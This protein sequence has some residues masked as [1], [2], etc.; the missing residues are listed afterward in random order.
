MRTTFQLLKGHEGGKER[1][2]LVVHVEI[3]EKSFEKRVVE[4]EVKHKV[5]VQGGRA[6]RCRSSNRL[7]GLK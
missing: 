5:N 6:P 2:E 3:L 1:Q 4:G 7:K